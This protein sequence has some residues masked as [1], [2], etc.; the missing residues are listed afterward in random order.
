MTS[1]RILTIANAAAALVM[2]GVSLYWA[3]RAR[4]ANARFMELAERA[5]TT[6]GARRPG[7]GTK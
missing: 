4:R 5:S 2:A 3:R 7:N 1:L 6:R